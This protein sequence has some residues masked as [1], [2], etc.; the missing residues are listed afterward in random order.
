MMIIEAKRLVKRYSIDG[1][2][3]EAL[4]G[5][6]FFL[7]EG[8][9]I[10][11][12][13]PSGAGKSTLLH[14]LGLLENPTE[15][16]LLFRGR[17]VGQ[18]TD[19]ERSRI[20]LQ[21]IGF[22]FQFHHLLPEFTALENV[23]L[24][25][26]MLN[27]TREEAQN[28]AQELLKRIGLEERMNHK[29]GELSGGEQQRVAFAR[30]LIN[31]PHL[32]LADEPTGNLDQEHANQLKTLLCELCEQ[33]GRALVLVTHNSELANGLGKTLFIRDGRFEDIPMGS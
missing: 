11:I 13:G 12:V 30:A 7:E 32:I 28:R 8:E 25:A 21:E 24:P 17:S 33:Q 9:R 20:R 10:V 18:L 15:G 3:V 6:D 2:E 27:R 5:I 14:L 1:S 22:V 23:M 29:P 19:E 26:L 16:I 4:R 31:N